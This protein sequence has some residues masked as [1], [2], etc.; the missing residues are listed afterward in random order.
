MC[1]SV[2]YELLEISDRDGLSNSSSRILFTM[3]RK[4]VNLLHNLVILPIT[5]CLS[6]LWLHNPIHV[7]HPQRRSRILLTMKGDSTACELLCQTTNSLGYKFAPCDTLDDFPFD[8]LKHNCDITRSHVINTPSV[9]KEFNPDV[10]PG[11]FDVSRFEADS[12]NDF[13]QVDHFLADVAEPAM[14]S[15]S[16][17]R[18]DT[19]AN[20][21][22]LA[23]YCELLSAVNSGRMEGS[24]FMSGRNN[25]RFDKQKDSLA[26]ETRRNIAR[27]TSDNRGV[28]LSFSIRSLA[29][30]KELTQL[31][32]AILAS[33]C[34][35]DGTYDLHPDSVNQ[36]QV[37]KA[38]RSFSLILPNVLFKSDSAQI[39]DIYADLKPI[40]NFA[41]PQELSGIFR[42]PVASE[43]FRPQ[44]LVSDTDP[45]A[46]SMD[47]IVP[48][49]WE[50]TDHV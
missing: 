24:G 33:S 43:S 47:D 20:S 49:G 12:G 4:M 6:L 27:L 39:N 8:K 14:W 41:S 23:R 25:L 36:T 30:S 48:L 18:C 44:C 15:F 9:S 13:S 17:Q 3:T 42:L 16:V 22:V 50:V 7:C 37:V 40:V 19:A 28:G 34:F 31:L 26:D 35:C 32:A 21:R 1:K 2:C 45:P 29:F 38:I 10:L 46:W 5:G 11:Y